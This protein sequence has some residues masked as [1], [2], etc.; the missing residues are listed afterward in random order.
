MQ[1]EDERCRRKM[2]GAVPA[3][4]VEEE[5]ERQHRGGFKWRLRVGIMLRYRLSYC[6]NPVMSSSIAITVWP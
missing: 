1:E 5:D 6:Q 3:K 2:E 4:K